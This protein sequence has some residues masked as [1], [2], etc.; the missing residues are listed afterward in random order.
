MNALSAV[1]SWNGG[2]CGYYRHTHDVLATTP[3]HSG[4][5]VF[6]ACTCPAWI[7]QPVM[8]DSPLTHRIMG[9]VGLCKTEG[10]IVT[11]N[12]CKQMIYKWYTNDIHTYR[13][14]AGILCMIMW[15]LCMHVCCN[16]HNTAKTLYPTMQ[17]TTWPSIS[18]V[19][20]ELRV[21]SSP[22][23]VMFLSDCW[24]V[25][26][27]LLLNIINVTKCVCG[28]Q[29]LVL[30]K[31]LHEFWA[32]LLYNMQKSIMYALINVQTVVFKCF[33]SVSGIHKVFHIQLSS[34]KH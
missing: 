30:N 13:F 14:Y 23:W 21:M 1:L 15:I 3:P 4:F 9:S 10:F 29:N 22:F 12:Y 11:V 32:L 2:V 8:P 31:S 34:Q 20:N 18:S 5:H 6:P 26:H 28:M 33:N 27:R 25:D 7:T 19:T 17:C 16:V 24:S